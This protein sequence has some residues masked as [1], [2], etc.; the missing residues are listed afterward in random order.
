MTTTTERQPPPL[1]GGDSKVLLHS[2][3][4]PCPGEVIEAM[5][6]SGIDFTIFFYNPNIHPLKEYELRKN[7]NIRVAR[8]MLSTPSAIIRP[9]SPD[10]MA[11]AAVPSASRLEPH[12]RFMEAPGTSSG[13]PANR[14]LIVAAEGRADGVANNG[15]DDRHGHMGE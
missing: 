4:A 14:L 7:E 13:S 1:P 10:R 11:R 2:C 3:C 5:Q 6:A 8:L 15:L 12:R 9:A